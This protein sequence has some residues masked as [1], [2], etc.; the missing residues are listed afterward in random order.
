M[1]NCFPQLLFHT[2]GHGT[3]SEFVFCEDLPVR[4]VCEESTV[5]ANDIDD[6]DCELEHESR[7]KPTGGV[8]GCHTT[9]AQFLLA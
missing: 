4:S 9:Q 8:W 3:K 1:K 5:K 2:P 7:P 6:S